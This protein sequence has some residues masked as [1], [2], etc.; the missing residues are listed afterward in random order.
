[1]AE[2]RGPL[3]G[4]RIVELAGIG[5]VPFAGMLLADMGAEILL[6]EPPTARE[7]QMPLPPDR[8]P[9]FRG[10]ARLTLDLKNAADRERLLSIIANADILLEGYRPGVM[11]RLGLGPDDCFKRAPR[12]V[13]G[14]MTGWGQTGPLAQAA[15]H[16]PN[17]IALVGVLYSI[18]YPDRP[19]TPP[20]NVVGDFAGGSL[21]LIMGVLAALMHARATGEGQVVD[22]AMIDGA[23]SLMTMVYSMY[24]A[25]AW[26]AERGTNI[27]DGSC[28]FGSCY[29]TA[30]GGFMVTCA[31]E[32]TFFR[33][34]VTRLGIDPATLPPQWDRARWPEMRARFAEAFA[35]RTRDEWAA[36]FADSD[37]CATPVLSI[38]EAPHHPHNV[39]RNVF[40]GDNKLPAPAPRFSKT[41]SAHAPAR[42]DAKELLK[43]WGVESN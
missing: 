17:Y 18:G 22:A 26:S 5:P 16:D 23:A 34:L 19:P 20:L 6:I 38:A 7:A 12:L 43:A 4:V 15:G 33:E 11:E 35:K 8:D 3:R 30:D 39:A 13:Y 24:S 27:M 32:P 21:Y 28:P 9:L 37:A 2:R 1:M 29:T 10:R 14:R 40:I 41:P 36:I 31:L 25:G 42:Q